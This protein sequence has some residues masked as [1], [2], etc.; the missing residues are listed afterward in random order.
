MLFKIV[1]ELTKRFY[2]EKN[3]A[4]NSAQVNSRGVVIRVPV[5]LLF[6]SRSLGAFTSFTLQTWHLNSHCQWSE[7]Q[8]KE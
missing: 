7:K 8:N 1:S 3:W 4:K 6:R 2:E 5:L